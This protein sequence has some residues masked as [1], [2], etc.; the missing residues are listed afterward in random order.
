MLTKLKDLG[1]HYAT[2]KSKVKRRVF[3]VLCSGCDREHKIQA[4][5][6]NAGWTNWCLECGKKHKGKN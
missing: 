2:S 5:Q 6:F 4:S 3:L 1:M